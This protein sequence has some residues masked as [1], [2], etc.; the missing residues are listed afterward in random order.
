MVEE[1]IL[2]FGKLNKLLIYLVTDL[3][4]IGCISKI[5]L[6]IRFSYNLVIR[7]VIYIYN[8]SLQLIQSKYAVTRVDNLGTPGMPHPTPERKLKCN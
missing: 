4:S 6:T 7:S 1:R 2:E 3:K 5:I 8:K